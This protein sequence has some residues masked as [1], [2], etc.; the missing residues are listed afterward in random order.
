MERQAS[1]V[2]SHVLRRFALSSSCPD[3]TSTKLSTCIN[4]SRDPLHSGRT[5]VDNVAK[6]AEYKRERER[7]IDETK[8]LQN[9]CGLN[10]VLVGEA[11]CF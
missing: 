2:L 6:S 3:E 4:I 7:L 1:N 11:R 8:R 9:N 10:H 5:K